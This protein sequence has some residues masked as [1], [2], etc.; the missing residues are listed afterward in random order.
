MNGSSNS[1]ATPAFELA[2]FDTVRLWLLA[3]V[4]LLLPVSQVLEVSG[5][6]INFSY[7]DL[8]LPLAMPLLF[9]RLLSRGFRF[10]VPMLFL[11][12]AGLVCVSTAVNLDRAL[13]LRG[14]VSQ[15]VEFVKL[16]SLWVYFYFFTNFLDTRRDLELML[17]CWIGS[18]TV[19][20]LLGSAGSLAF[21]HA[22]IVTPFS[23]H[24]R[25]QGT[26]DD[27]NLFSAHCGLTLM[28]ALL[29]WRLTGARWP[30]LAIPAL[31]GGILLS[32][33]R[34]SL[35]SVTLALG[36][37]AFLFAPVAV[38]LSIAFAVLMA[39]LGVAALPNRDEVLAGNPI[40][41][42][43]T[44]ATVDL[45]NP[46]AQQRRELWEVAWHTWQAH[47]WLGVGKGNYGM[48]E[49]G[50]AG[51]IGVAHSTYLGTL[52]ELGI[53]GFLVYGLL[54]FRLV[55]PV[56]LTVWHGNLPAGILLGGLL[57]ILLAGV[58]ISIENYRGLWVL[59]AVF[60]AYRRLTAPPPD[61]RRREPAGEVAYADAA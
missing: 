58:T 1:P 38:R 49:G 24:F 44:T 2:R 19:V 39:V 6:K 56:A 57:V 12:S 30:W 18:G 37:L 3:G 20:A 27:A 41:A 55:G 8:L 29:H 7:A 15:V 52:A 33:S 43:L 47:P 61:R 54:M 16:L 32:A 9:W 59:M 51:T 60:E 22:G 42:R 26:F 10:P 34:G 45:D 5:K 53:F 21:Q 40:T 31:L 28:L 48:G 23:L 36:C 11:A 4:T 14:P 50:E 17:R 25:A 46:E 13:D 35:I